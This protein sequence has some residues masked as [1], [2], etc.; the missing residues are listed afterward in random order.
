MDAFSS[1]SELSD[2]PTPGPPQTP[3]HLSPAAAAAPQPAAATATPA[4]S[5]QAKYGKRGGGVRGRGQAA[6]ARRSSRTAQPSGSSPA[7]ADEAIGDALPADE[8]PAS[9]APVP[10]PSKQKSRDPKRKR[11]I[12]P[13]PKLEVPDACEC[14]LRHEARRMF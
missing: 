8:A 13:P 10:I 6:G 14:P 5:K 1:S 2:A 9:P 7:A 12:V 4:S 3:G 11:L